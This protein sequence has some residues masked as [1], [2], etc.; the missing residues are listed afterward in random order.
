MGGLCGNESD[1]VAVADWRKGTV[2]GGNVD[3]RGPIAIDIIYFERSDLRKTVGKKTSVY[4]LAQTPWQA[5]TCTDGE[6][7]SAAVQSMRESA[8]E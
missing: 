2:Y 7:R 5:L 3:R 8:Q 6:A 1:N 4:L